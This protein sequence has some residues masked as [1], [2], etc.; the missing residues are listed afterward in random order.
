MYTQTV[1]IKKKKE[2]PKNIGTAAWLEFC[3]KKA[4]MI[5]MSTS[6]TPHIQYKIYRE[7]SSHSIQDLQGTFLKFDTRSTRNTPQVQDKMHMVFIY[8]RTVLINASW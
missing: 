3:P 6:N 2:I 8:L 7:H 4:V 5:K 1:M